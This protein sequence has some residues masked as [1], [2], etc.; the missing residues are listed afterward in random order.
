MEET[1]NLYGSSDTSNHLLHK[2]RL[3]TLQDRLSSAKDEPA[4]SALPCRRIMGQTAYRNIEDQANADMLQESSRFPILYTTSSEGHSASC[5]NFLRSN[6]IKLCY[7]NR[8]PHT[9][10]ER[11]FTA[12]SVCRCS[13]RGGPRI[14]HRWRDDRE[15]QS[16]GL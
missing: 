8:Y 15:V 16:G 2:S 6:H 10:K 4:V 13:V 5:D 7:S 12:N 1:A 3:R 9:T 14:F 11:E